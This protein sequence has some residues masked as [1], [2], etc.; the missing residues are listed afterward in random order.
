[1][2]SRR[3]LCALAAAAALAASGCGDG[4]GGAPAGAPE[5]RRA[6]AAV[7]PAARADIPAIVDAVSP[8]VVAVLVQGVR[9]QG[10]GSGVVWREDGT[11][12]TNAHVVQGAGEVEVRLAGGE[13]LPAR[14]VAAA[15]AFDLAVLEVDRR[16]PAVPFADALPE[17]GELAVAIGNPLGFEGTATA[18]IVS[19]LDRALPTG[20]RTPALVGLL[21][22]DASISPGNSGGALVDAEGR[23]IGINVAY[24]PPAARAVSIGFAIPAPV[25]VQVAEELLADGEVERPYLGVALGPLPPTAGRSVEEGVLVAAVEPGGPAEAAGIER[26]D[27]VVRVGEREVRASRTSTRR[28]ASARPASGWTSRA[29]GPTGGARRSRCASASC[30]ARRPRASPP[31]ERQGPRLLSAP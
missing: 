25:A 28:C 4:D 21:Q 2:G 6:P 3:H 20:G 26:G 1:V 24:V 18:G 16:L 23:V 9:G 29:C 22:T 30:P 15:P 8:S 17:V 10:Q 11:I 27:V 19:G 14:V 7:A 12:V 31:P 13:E 5:P